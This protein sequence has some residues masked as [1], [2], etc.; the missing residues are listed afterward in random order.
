MYKTALCHA[1]RAVSACRK[2]SPVAIFS[3]KHW[4][5]V[6]VQARK[7][8]ARPAKPVDT[9]EIRRDYDPSDTTLQGLLT[10]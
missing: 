9:N 8:P 2:S 1:Q 5:N 3:A 6:F 4:W 10:I 7:L